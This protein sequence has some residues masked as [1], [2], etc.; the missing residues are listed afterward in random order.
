MVYRH[1]SHFAFVTQ[2]RYT[3]YAIYICIYFYWR[4]IPVGRSFADT[5]ASRVRVSWTKTTR[6]FIGRPRRV[7]VV[8]AAMADG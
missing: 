6:P 5:P 3:L 2:T 7:V 8:V 1:K 4:D